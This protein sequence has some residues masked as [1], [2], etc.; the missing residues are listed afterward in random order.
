[1]WFPLTDIFKEGVY[2]W[3][4]GTCKYFDDFVIRKTS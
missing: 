3:Q 1:M 4:D 2:Q